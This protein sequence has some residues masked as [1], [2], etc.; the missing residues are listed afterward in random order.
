[1][2]LYWKNIWTILLGWEPGQEIL[3][4]FPAALFVFFWVLMT[5][6]VL[7]HVTKAFVPEPLKE[8]ILEFVKTMTFC[9]YPMGHVLVFKSLGVPGLAVGI[10]LAVIIT[11]ACLKD[12]AGN[13]L[14]VWV[15][16]FEKLIP[17]RICLLKNFI[18]IAAGCSAYHLSMFIIS[19]ELSPLYSEQLEPYRKGECES[20]L[21]VSV[22]SGFLLEFSGALYVIWFMY[23]KL[24]K[25][26]VIDQLVKVFNLV[27]V[28][29][30][31]I[32]YTG[33]HIH[34][35]KATGLTW[36]CGS[37]PKWAHVL[38]YWV[39]PLLGTWLAVKFS[40]IITIDRRKQ[41]SEKKTENGKEKNSPKSSDSIYVRNQ[42]RKRRT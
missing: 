26:V 22:L 19:T 25:T 21:K 39:A 3:A 40:K 4:P 6:L 31:G 36:G 14:N 35:A 30:S 29:L 18:Q 42:V 10:S 9:A 28:V 17:L 16:Y 34:P 15:A 2:I 23:Q 37:T 27:V 5:G 11:S 1:M 8:Y 20:H 33:M 41:T 24:F 38:I 7:Y 12:G 13:P 32:R